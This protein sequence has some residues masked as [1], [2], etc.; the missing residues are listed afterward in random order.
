M[1]FTKNPMNHTIRRF[2]ILL[3]LC[4]IYQVSAAQNNL[5]IRG[6]IT[7]PNGNTPLIGVSIKE[8]GTS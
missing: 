7:D 3:M 1:N 4:L 2:L 8:K 5:T 6:K